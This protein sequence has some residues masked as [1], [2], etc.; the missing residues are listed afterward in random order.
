MGSEAHS[1]TAPRTAPFARTAGAR[2]TAMIVEPSAPDF[3][4]R[5]NAPSTPAT[6]RRPAASGL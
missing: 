5:V 6:G 2:W 1:S 3:C 4:V